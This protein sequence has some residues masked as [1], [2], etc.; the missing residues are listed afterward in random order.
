M[1]FSIRAPR[2]RASTGLSLI[3]TF[4]PPLLYRT[5]ANFL[6]Q[7]VGLKANHVLH[8]SFADSSPVQIFLDSLAIGVGASQMAGDHHGRAGQA[9]SHCTQN[10]RPM[11]GRALE[12]EEFV[13]HELDEEYTR[14]T[15]RACHLVLT[16]TQYLCCGCES[17]CVRFGA[18]TKVMKP[19]R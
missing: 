8:L 5:A 9:G 6:V 2:T 1:S 3:S 16:K 11:P 12:K 14:Q 19:H 7:L 18:I 17:K 15:E 4:R 10:L 13:V